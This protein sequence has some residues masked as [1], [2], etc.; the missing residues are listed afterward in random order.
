[1]YVYVF[2]CILTIKGFHFNFTFKP[3]SKYS[4]L[5]LTFSLQQT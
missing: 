3:P 5:S 1:M 2:D 4:H